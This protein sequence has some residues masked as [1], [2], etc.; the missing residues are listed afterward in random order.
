[1]HNI[2]EIV[3]QYKLAVPTGWCLD[4][5]KKLGRICWQ[6]ALNAKSTLGP[7]LSDS[8]MPVRAAFVFKGLDQTY[9]DTIPDN[10][11]TWFYIDRKD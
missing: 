11:N 4:M 2:V 1:M 10:L 9:P 6:N 5:A 3:L 8:F 7:T